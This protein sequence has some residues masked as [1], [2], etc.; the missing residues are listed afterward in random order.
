MQASSSREIA[1]SLHQLISLWWLKDPPEVIHPWCIPTLIAGSFISAGHHFMIRLDHPTDCWFMDIQPWLSTAHVAHW[2]LPSIHIIMFVNRK[3]KRIIN[4]CSVGAF[5]DMRFYHLLIRML[6]GWFSS[7]SLG[8]YPYMVD[9][10]ERIITIGCWYYLWLSNHMLH[11]PWD[12]SPVMQ[13]HPE[14]GK[15]PRPIPWMWPWKLHV[16]HSGRHWHRS[17]TEIL[18]PGVGPQQITST[19]H[20]ES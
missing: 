4:Q 3:V 18:D 15:P 11:Y 16:Q 5:F 1:N 7:A 19:S 2:I 14:L 10:W 6:I 13:S 17:H 8:Y 20:S 9:P 12:T